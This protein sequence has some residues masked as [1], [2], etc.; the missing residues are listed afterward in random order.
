LGENYFV[1]VRNYLRK[2]V[3]F[4]NH[5]KSEGLDLQRVHADFAKQLQAEPCP[6]KIW[7]ACSG[8]LD[9]SVLLFLLD[10]LQRQLGTF[11]LG[12]LHVNYALRGSESDRDE[13]LVRQAALIYGR[14]LR[15]LKLDPQQHTRQKTGIQDW[16]R[17]I[18]Y[19]WFA[20]QQ[21]VGDWIAVAHHRDDW[22]ETIF[23]R[24]CRGHSLMAIAGMQVLHEG[25][26]RPLLDMTRQEIEALGRC[27]QV[28]FGEDSSNHS[29]DYT[30]NR[31]RQQI[32]PELERLFP[33]L[34]E[35]I[36]LHAQD[37]LDC[38]GFHQQ[39]LPELHLQETLLLSDLAARPPFLARHE[40]GRYLQMQAPNARVSRDLLF[41]IHRALTQGS[42]WTAMLEPGTLAVCQEGRLSIVRNQMPV[43]QRWQQFRAALLDESLDVWPPAAP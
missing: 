20:Q 28:A 6:A 33:G 1:E 8:G 36:R 13:N 43:S 15:V 37:L 31:L 39:K 42:P 9:S 4:M 18:R 35:N 3:F 32:L 11:E 25:I 34:A 7:V 40:I 30:R 19:E 22:V 17:A 26:W 10:G 14:E 24:L 21:G 38:V 27:H 41:A 5:Q 2:R 12:V 16:A 29:L 23:A